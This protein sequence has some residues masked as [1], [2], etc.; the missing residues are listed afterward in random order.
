MFDPPTSGDCLA[1]ESKKLLVQCC[2]AA[3]IVLLFMAYF[4][5]EI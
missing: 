4:F 5:R 2:F 3:E 1:L